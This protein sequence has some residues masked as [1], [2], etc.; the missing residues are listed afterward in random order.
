M[1]KI[2]SPCPHILDIPEQ[3]ET[4][5]NKE[6]TEPIRTVIMSVIEKKKI[7]R[8]EEQ[9]CNAGGVSYFKSNL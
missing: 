9:K 2:R 3:G 6:D 1:D 5:K 4:F 7:S 8:E